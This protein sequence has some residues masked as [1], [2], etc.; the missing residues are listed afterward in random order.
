MF[1]VMAGC[2]A[3]YWFAMFWVSRKDVVKVTGK[4]PD[5]EIF[6]GKIP[7]DPQADLTRGRLCI[8]DERLV[9][10]QRTDD[11]IRKT[12]PCKEV[13]SIPTKDIKSLGFGKVLSMRKGLVIYFNDDEVS[14]TCS[15][16]V[17]DREPLYKALGWK[18]EAS[19]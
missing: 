6:A 14:F 17:K 2:V 8:M 12:E 18:M 10:F 9:L 19:K 15:K 3:F 5:F 16:I 13:W 7:S 4:E 11:K 1:V